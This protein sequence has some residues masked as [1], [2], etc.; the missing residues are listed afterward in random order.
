MMSTNQSAARNGPAASDDIVIGMGVTTSGEFAT[1]GSVFVDGVLRDAEVRSSLL[2]ISHG[3]E[4]HGNA[5]VKRLEIAGVWDGDAV[6]AEDIVLRASASVTGR[7]CAPYIVV[8]R[9]ALVR[10]DI[11]S[12]ERR[13]VPLRPPPSPQPPLGGI[14]LK[15][16]GGLMSLAVVGLVI[17]GGT[18]LALWI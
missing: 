10:G 3:G 1:A 4:F 16:G 7:L 8:H 11:E 17:S 9:G 14:R 13:P 12:L 5:N 18:V 15:R 6:A 2:S